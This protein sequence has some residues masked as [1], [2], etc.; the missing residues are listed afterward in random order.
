MGKMRYGHKVIAAK[1]ENM[2]LLGKLGIEE[3]MNTKMDV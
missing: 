2:R 1:P 3:N